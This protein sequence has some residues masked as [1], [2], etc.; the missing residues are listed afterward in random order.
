MGLNKLDPKLLALRSR[1]E[2]GNEIISILQNQLK[3]DKEEI[4]SCC[5]HKIVV[6][7]SDGHF[8]VENEWSRTEIADS[9]SP[10]FRICI[11]CGFEELG[12]HVIVS[13]RNCW[14][15][16]KLTNNPKH[17]YLQAALREKLRR[18]VEYPLNDLLD[19]MTKLGAKL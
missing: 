17:Q 16:K 1:I 12:K 5:D 15:F 4:Q 6:R 14:D 3:D 11:V 7:M 9:D 2:K 19:E 18:A 13:G 8:A 10:E